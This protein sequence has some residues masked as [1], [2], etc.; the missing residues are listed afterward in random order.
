MLREAIKAGTE[1]FGSIIEQVLACGVLRVYVD[2]K[3][4]REAVNYADTVVYKSNL[5]K[6]Q[7]VGMDS[8]INGTNKEGLFEVYRYKAIALFR[9]LTESESSLDNVQVYIRV[10]EILKVLQGALQ[11]LAGRECWLLEV[12]ITAKTK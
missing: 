1:R 2:G 10:G 7:D 9:M 3:M 11:Q 4:Y 12:R 5:L 6:L 8:N